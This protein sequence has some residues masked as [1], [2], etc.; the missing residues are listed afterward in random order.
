MV[1]VCRLAHVLF[2]SQTIAAAI[3][4]GILYEGRYVGGGGLEGQKEGRDGFQVLVL[5][6]LRD[7]DG[8]L[9]EPVPVLPPDD[10]EVAHAAGPGGAAA[11]GLHGPG[12]ERQEKHAKVKRTAD[13]IINTNHT[14]WPENTTD[15]LIP[16]AATETDEQV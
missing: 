13:T 2:Y 4:R 12:Q 6:L 1:C 14:K 8:A 15:T 7:G 11:A 16:L 5:L 9:A 3:T 10:G